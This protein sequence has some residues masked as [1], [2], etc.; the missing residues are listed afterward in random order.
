MFFKYL[1]LKGK[2]TYVKNQ[3]STE[4]ILVSISTYT[5]LKSTH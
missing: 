2:G 1:D 4:V 5:V 3:V